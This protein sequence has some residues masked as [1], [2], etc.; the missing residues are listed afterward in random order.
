MVLLKKLDCSNSV[1]KN[2]LCCS[3]SIIEK[4]A[5][6]Q[7]HQKKKDFSNGVIL[8]NWFA[9]PPL[10]KKMELLCNI[11]K[12]KCIPLTERDCIGSSS[13]GV[14]YSTVHVRTV[15]YTAFSKTCLCSKTL[16]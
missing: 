13:S 2:K 6:Q 9:P 12:Q 10:F 15:I 11:I 1:I 7:C 14:S 4:I 3:A 5:L 8:K 16:V